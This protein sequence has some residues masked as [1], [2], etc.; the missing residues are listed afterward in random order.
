MPIPKLNPFIACGLLCCLHIFSP[1]A[2]QQ[3]KNNFQPKY[4]V[5]S[6]IIEYNQRI[7]DGNDTIFHPSYRETYDAYGSLFLHEKIDGFT[8]GMRG[9]P[10]QNIYRDGYVFSLNDPKGCVTKH[11]IKDFDYTKEIDYAITMGFSKMVQDLIHNKINKSNQKNFISFRKTGETS[12]LGRVCSQ[13]EY[14]VANPAYLTKDKYIFVVYQDIC[15]SQKYYWGGSLLGTTEATSL[16]ENIAISPATFEVPAKYRMIDGD[17][18]DETYKQSASGF[19]TI[20]VNYTIKKD[21]YQT[22]AE[23]KK[24]L[25]SKDQGKKSVWEWEETISEYNLSPETKHYKKIRDEECEFLV[26]YIHKTVRRGDLV[27]GNYNYKSIAELNYLFKN[28]LYDTTVR[29]MGKTYFLGKDCTIYEII[30]GIEKLEVYEWQ[31][32]FLKVKQFICTV[33][34][35]CKQYVLSSEETA[36][37]VQVNVPIAESLF[38]YPN[39]FENVSN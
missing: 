22:K 7:H 23:G 4:P 2:A 18:L 11:K 38:Q 21:Y 8:I 35:D 36:I 16:E 30:T 26:D 28:K 39:D 14:I 3:A 37:S 33:V 9:E 31:G 15:L 27:N 12:F 20:I 32:V 34:P 25:Y 19:S 10:Y 1:V 5:K 6:A 24:T 29:E 13:Y 17:K